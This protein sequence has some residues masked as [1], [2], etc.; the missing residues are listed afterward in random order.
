MDQGAMESPLLC[1][2]PTQ[3]GDKGISSRSCWGNA[4]R[5]SPGLLSSP[6]PMA[7]SM[8]EW[9]SGEVLLLSH[10][11]SSPQYG[12]GG[13]IFH[14]IW[15]LEPIPRTP[16]AP[17]QQGSW[18]FDW[19]ALAYLR[20]C[21]CLLLASSHFGL[22]QSHLPPPL[23]NELGLLQSKKLSW[24]PK[25]CLRSGKDFSFLTKLANYCVGFFHLLSGILE[26]WP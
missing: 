11:L 18:W 5:A 24:S 16:A 7:C 6:P 20:G 14:I 13:W 17:G 1:F 8:C 12:E 21:F 23:S 10:S 3:V 19:L 26:V 22:F 15:V 25:F 9:E 2:P 4:V